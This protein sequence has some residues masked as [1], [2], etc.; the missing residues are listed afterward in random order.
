VQIVPRLKAMGLL[1]VKVDHGRN[2]KMQGPI[3][4]SC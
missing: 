1:A 3:L 2:G 4:K